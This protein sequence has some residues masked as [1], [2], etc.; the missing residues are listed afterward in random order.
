VKDGGP[1]PAP[2]SAFQRTVLLPNPRRHLHG[3]T[4]V[5]AK[6]LAAALTSPLYSPL[7][8]LVTSSAGMRWPTTKRPKSPY[9]EVTSS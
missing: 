6:P 5:R 2:T 9:T 4:R 7:N 8:S 1:K 3:P